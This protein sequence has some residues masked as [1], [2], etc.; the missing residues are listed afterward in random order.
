MERINPSLFLQWQE[1]SRRS[2]YIFVVIFFFCSLVWF[3]LLF[4]C[5]DMAVL[6]MY[7]VESANLRR[8]R[9][10]FGATN[11]RRLPPI[12]KEDARL[13]TWLAVAG[14]AVFTVGSSLHRLRQI[15]ANGSTFVTTAMG[16]IPLG[17]TESVLNS[18]AGKRRETILKNVIAEMSL[19][20][21]I[22]EPDVYV[23]PYENCINAMAVGLNLDDCAIVV[24]KGTL[25]YLDRDELSGVIGHELSHIIN[26]DMRHNTLMSG[27]LH[28]FFCLSS[29]GFQFLR[30]GLRAFYLIP[31]GFF[32]IAL[33]YLSDLNGRLIQA[34]FNRRRESM[35]DAYSIQFTRDPSCLARALKKIGGLNEGSYLKRKKRISLENRHLF[36]AESIKSL[37]MTHPALAERIWSLDPRW[38]GHWHD[39]EANP[40]DFL[41]PSP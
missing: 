33:G 39:F 12:K 37:F 9:I 28:G 1:D 18:E 22:P 17:E 10:P 40:V 23:L 4:H 8:T 38:S 20:A 13:V 29:I 26:G 21:S 36:I 35:A 41:A 25:R 31:A 32:L 16:A 30:F 15:K 14:F 24:T 34:A 11:Y 6:K 3:F 5:V 2:S 19:A 27:W 7:R